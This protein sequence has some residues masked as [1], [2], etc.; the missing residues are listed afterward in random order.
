MDTESDVERRNKRKK[1][2]ETVMKKE[3]KRNRDIE[4]NAGRKK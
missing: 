1:M 3:L 2:Q 4:N